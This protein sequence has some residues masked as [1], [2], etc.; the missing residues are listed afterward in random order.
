MMTTSTFLP[1]FH[2]LGEGSPGFQNDHPVATGVPP[3]PHS[4]GP[5]P[6]MSPST[7]AGVSAP[8]E[9]FPGSWLPS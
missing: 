2:G 4:I 3:R 8:R 6:L 7:S 9:H 1:L 5:W